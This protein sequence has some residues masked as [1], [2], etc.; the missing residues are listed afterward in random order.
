[1]VRAPNDQF[2][3]RLVRAHKERLPSGG[4]PVGVEVAQQLTGATTTDDEVLVVD[5]VLSDNVVRITFDTYRT[6]LLLTSDAG[7]LDVNQVRVRIYLARLDR[8]QNTVLTKVVSTTLTMRAK[9]TETQR[10]DDL[11]L[12]GPNRPGFPR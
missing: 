5:R 9:N 7:R 12:L 2:L 6:D 1:M 11:V 4:L 8:I 3:S 10:A